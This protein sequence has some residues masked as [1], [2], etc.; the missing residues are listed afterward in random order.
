[1]KLHIYIILFIVVFLS[2]N[3]NK[4]TKDKNKG[5]NSLVIDSLPIGSDFFFKDLIDKEKEQKTFFEYYDVNNS[6]F[7]RIKTNQYSSFYKP[8]KADTFNEEDSFA[9]QSISD[10][11]F[12]DLV[13]VLPKKNN[14]YIMIF[15][16]E[17]IINDYD[18]NV[19]SVDRKDLVVI[20]EN[21]KIISEMNLYYDYSNGI[22]ARMKSFFI[23]KEG[24]IYIKYYFEDEE[25][26]SKFSNVEKYMINDKGEILKK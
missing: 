14:F 23:D 24:V 18:G 3:N 25:G 10:Y 22:F 8:T 21:H 16:G 15:G 12:F 17:S 11:S 9:L 7:K 2:C 13:K 20:D 1:M 6:N 4:F 19:F 5:L 26:S